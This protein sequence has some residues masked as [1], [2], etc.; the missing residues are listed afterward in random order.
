MLDGQLDMFGGEVRQ[1]DEYDRFVEKFTPKKTTDDCYTPTNIYDAVARYV[2]A[3]YGIRREQM[4]RPFWPG[5]N[6]QAVDYPDGCCVVDNPPFSILSEIAR[7][8]CARGI[9]FFLFAPTLTMISGNG[10]K[11]DISYIALGISIIYENGAEI[12]TSFITN[13]DDS[14]LRSAPALY[15]DLKDANE[16]NRQKLHKTLPKYEY[17]PNVLTAAAAYRYS[18]YGVEYKLARKDAVFIRALDAQRGKGKAIFGGGLLLSERAAAERAAAERA[19]AERAAAERAAA[20]RW[21]S[22]EREEAI[23]ARLGHDE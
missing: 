21:P 5:A 3:E 17:P 16:K 19:A 12:N 14:L 11:N 20:N 18:Q 23:I 9:S 1:N 6:Y 10:T 15:R 4:V 13:L 8:Y 7:W 22:S 2:G